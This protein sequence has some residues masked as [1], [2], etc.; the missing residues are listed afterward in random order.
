[1]VGTGKLYRMQSEVLLDESDDDVDDSEEEDDDA[2]PEL[3][4]SVSA[5]ELNDK[6]PETAKIVR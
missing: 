4:H 2:A 1:M 5:A 3:S 6:N